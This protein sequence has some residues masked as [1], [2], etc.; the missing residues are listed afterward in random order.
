MSTTLTVTGMSCEHCEARVADALSEVSGV[1]AATAD[2]ERELATIDGE[3]SLEDLIAAV[4]D[5]GY[6]AS[7]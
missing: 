4:E 1:T 5:A 6:D 3:A 2:R 7:A